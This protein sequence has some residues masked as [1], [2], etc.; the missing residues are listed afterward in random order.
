MQLFQVEEKQ[1]ADI[2]IK[3]RARNEVGDVTS[4]ANSIKMVGQLTPILIDEDNVLIDG[5]HRLK[6]IES[7][8]L[9]TVEARVVFGITQDDHVLIE[10]LSNMDRKEFAW[11]EEI[12]IKYKLHNY[13]KEAAEKDNKTW[14]YRETAKR[15]HCSLGGLSTD[16]AFAEALKVFPELKKQT[17]KGRAR[18]LY[19]AFGDQAHAIQRMDNF[20]DVEKDRLNALQSGNFQIPKKTKKPAAPVMQKD[21][22]DDEDQDQ[23]QEDFLLAN[24]EEKEAF[25]NIQV[26]YVAENYNHN[27]H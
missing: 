19:K 9:K 3:E 17:T 25:Q 18:E 21:L 26:I 10:L 23:E 13:W 1:I 12:E 5:L 8:G 16:L 4:L 14:G 24:E 22:S 20:T 27:S 2:I 7:L 6:A 15:L 11:H